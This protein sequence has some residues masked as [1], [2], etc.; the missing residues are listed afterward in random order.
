MRGTLKRGRMANAM[1]QPFD[2]L[3]LGHWH[4]LN[5]LP[6][7]IIN[8]S[9]KGF[10]EFAMSLSITPEPAAQALWLTTETHGRTILLPVY[11]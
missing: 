9:L 2:F 3:L 7:T 4:T 6:N 10:D 8:G 5:F 1:G 11:A